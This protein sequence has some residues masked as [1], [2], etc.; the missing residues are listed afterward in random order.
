MSEEDDSDEAKVSELVLRIPIHLTIEIAVIEGPSE[1]QADSEATESEPGLPTAPSAPEESPPPEEPL[2][3]QLLLKHRRDAF[4]S[5][6][7]LAKLAGLA[8]STIRNFE[9]NRHQ[10][11]V[12]TVNRLRAV[13]VLNLR[14]PPK[15]T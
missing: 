1:Q 3:G 10:P 9:R 8:E 11:T 13:A 15:P 12:R 4:L 5:R 7:A 6:R 14:R 2:T